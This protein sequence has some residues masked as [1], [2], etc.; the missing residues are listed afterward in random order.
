MPHSSTAE[1]SDKVVYRDPAV[2]IYRHT[3][4]KT[5]RYPYL[6]HHLCRSRKLLPLYL[7]AA[8]PSTMSPSTSSTNL[9][10]V[11]GIVA[12]VTGGGSGTS[13]FLSRT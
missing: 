11:S 8:L 1:P 2:Q 4:L 3:I 6:Y 10:D 13:N 5:I 7:Q 12:V 9:F